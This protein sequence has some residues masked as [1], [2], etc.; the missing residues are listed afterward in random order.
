MGRAPR[1]REA[2]AARLPGSATPGGGRD[3]RGSG[4]DHRFDGYMTVSIGV[5]IYLSEDIWDNWIFRNRI[6][7]KRFRFW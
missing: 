5:E 6:N 1:I 2:S 4:L 7:E 3:S